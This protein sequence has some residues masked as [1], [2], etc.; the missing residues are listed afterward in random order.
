MTIEIPLS[1]NLVALIDNEDLPLVEGYKWCAA[2]VRNTF[3]ARHSLPW[4]GNKR[5]WLEMHRVI[6]NAQPGQVVDHRNRNGLDNT[7]ANLRV[8]TAL[9]NNYNRFQQARNKTGY[10][11][12]SWN[13]RVGKFYAQIKVAGRN[14]DLGLYA[15]PIE[16]ARAY[17]AAARQH[18]GEFA[19]LNFPS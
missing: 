5:P 13:G 2:P 8:C 3:Y 17:D 6:L 1:R 16:A 7:R 18:F 19:Y 11:G 10:K 15:D 12:V 9:Q 14:Y 4:Q